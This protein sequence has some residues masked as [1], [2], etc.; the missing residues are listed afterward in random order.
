MAAAD[1]NVEMVATIEEAITIGDGESLQEEATVDAILA[2][3]GVGD[4]G[5]KPPAVDSKPITRL[6]EKNVAHPLLV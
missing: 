2:V 4:A 3:V 1:G 6:N 5:R